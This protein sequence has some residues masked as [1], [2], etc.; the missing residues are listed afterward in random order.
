MLHKTTS[1]RLL[2]VEQDS[3]KKAIVTIWEAAQIRMQFD[4][5]ILARSQAGLICHVLIIRSLYDSN[6]TCGCRC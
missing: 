2:I 6:W 4:P 5:A 1:L 3:H